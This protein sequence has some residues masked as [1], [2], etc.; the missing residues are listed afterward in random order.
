MDWEGTS[1]GAE[2]RCEE[3][4]P[5]SAGAGPPAAGMAWYSA[6]RYL[7]WCSGK[8]R[9]AKSRERRDVLTCVA[10]S[11]ATPLLRKLRDVDMEYQYNKITNLRLAVDR[12]TACC[13][14]PERP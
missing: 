7:L 2:L 6:R 4:D 14:G 9:F 1:R 8:Y 13:C 10:A 5:H 3:D 12:L 11:H